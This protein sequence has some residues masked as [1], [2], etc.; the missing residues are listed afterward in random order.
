MGPPPPPPP[1]PLRPRRGDS[2][3]LDPRENQFLSALSKFFA[4]LKLTVI[5]VKTK[6]L[7]KL[8]IVLYYLLGTFWLYVVYKIFTCIY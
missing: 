3:L 5:H 4:I 1:P 8:L 7:H 6:F 2:M